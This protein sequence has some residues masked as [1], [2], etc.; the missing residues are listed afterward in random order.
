MNRN[1]LYPTLGTGLALGG[2]AL[3]MLV[4]NPARGRAQSTHAESVPKPV[5]VEV[6]SPQRHNLIRQ[7]SYPGTVQPWE[8][9]QLYAKAS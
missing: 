7:E 8:E 4:L 1:W 3:G 2:L 5:A 6:V 9:T